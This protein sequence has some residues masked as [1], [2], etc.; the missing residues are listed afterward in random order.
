MCLELAEMVILLFKSKQKLITYTF[1]PVCRLWF[2]TTLF[3]E[4]TEICD[5]EQD[6]ER[7]SRRWNECEERKGIHWSVAQVF[8]AE[9]QQKSE[10][11]WRQDSQQLDKKI[12]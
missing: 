4:Y 9:S 3:K 12:T 8:E 2:Q 6:T 1:L 11:H 10:K 5:K 7:Q